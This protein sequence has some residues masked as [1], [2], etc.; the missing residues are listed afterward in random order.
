MKKVLL[1]LVALAVAQSALAQDG[2]KRRE[3]IGIDGHYS[4][5]DNFDS[6]AGALS[7]SRLALSKLEIGAAYAFEGSKVGN[8]RA[9]RLQS[10]QVF[11]RQWFGPVAQADTVVPFLQAAAGMEFA[12]SKYEN[13]VGLG[14]GVGI[15]VSSQSEFRFTFKGEWGGFADRTRVDAGYFYH[16]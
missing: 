7:Y 5:S 16:F 14:G 15:F 9:S 6:W 12:D 3:T 11:G 1:T 8:A 2:A 13:I 4:T 10:L